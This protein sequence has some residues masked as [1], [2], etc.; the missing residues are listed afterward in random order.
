MTLDEHQGRWR[1]VEGSEEDTGR[2]ALYAHSS[3]LKN[4]ET[5]DPRRRCYVYPCPIRIERQPDRFIIETRLFPYS[6]GENLQNLVDAGSRLSS[7]NSRRSRQQ[8]RLH[9]QILEPHWHLQNLGVSIV[10]ERCGHGGPLHA[11]YHGPRMWHD[12]R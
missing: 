3:L 1:K 8:R 5:L 10:Q 4:F 11:T 7:K 2:I 6:E 12:S 9:L